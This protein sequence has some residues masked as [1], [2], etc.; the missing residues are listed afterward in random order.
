MSARASVQQ[1]TYAD[2]CE[3]ERAATVKHEYLRGEVFAMTG[4]T[5]EHARLIGRVIHL[6]SRELASGPCRVFSSDARVRVEETDLDTYPDVSVVCGEPETSERS[7]LA[8]VNPVLLVEV[9]SDSTEAYDRGQKAAHY[10]RIPSL[11]GYLLVSQHEPRL[12][13]FV[14]RDDG[15]W[16][17]FEASTGERLSIEFLAVSI[18][19]D[20]VY[21]AAL[22]R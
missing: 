7:E 12:E 11:R 3:L 2:Y 17:L 10:R 4:G 1:M 22:P 9:L 18:A 15:G 20:E 6:L 19:V 5:L 8:L 14:R 13:L 16:S 21:Q